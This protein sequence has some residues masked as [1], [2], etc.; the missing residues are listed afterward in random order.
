MIKRITALAAALALGVVNAAT[1]TTPAVADTCSWQANDHCRAYVRWPVNA[2]RGIYG[3][4]EPDYQ[5]FTTLDPSA[6]FVTAEM[7][8]SP[9]DDDTTWIEAGDNRGAP[10]GSSIVHFWAA[11]ADGDYHQ[12]QIPAAVPNFSR[13]FD[14]ERDSDWKWRVRM[15]GIFVGKEAPSSF[16][17]EAS[18]ADAGIESQDP[19]AH[20]G[21]EIKALGYYDTNDNPH[22]GWNSSNYHPTTKTHGDAFHVGWVTQYEYISL[23]ANPCSS[24]SPRQRSV[25]RPVTEKTLTKTVH[26]LTTLNGE[27]SPQ[28]IEMVQSS[29]PMTKLG[30][31]NSATTKN[32]PVVT[33]QTEGKNKDQ[34]ARVPAGKRSPR[35][36]YLTASSEE[37]TGKVL[38]WGGSSRPVDLS[39]VGKTKSL[40]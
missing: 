37:A 19:G 26:Q 24:E 3:H 32:V 31:G 9:K 10:F 29:K 5:C 36:K 39:H 7:W 17:S 22:W 16:P 2:I 25:L 1:G 23:W 38:D 30:A 34:Q 21:G 8:I 11:S 40:R 33:I 15:D 6:T 28:N 14:I 35:G 13:T 12:Y 18:L 20:V 27:A 4:I